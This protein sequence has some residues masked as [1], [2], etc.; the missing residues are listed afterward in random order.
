MESGNNLT[1]QEL[2]EIVDASVRITDKIMYVVWGLL[3]LGVAA[4]CY[5]L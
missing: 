5:F 3:V 2:K 1:P 4:V